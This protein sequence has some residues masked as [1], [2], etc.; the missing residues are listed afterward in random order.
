M[1]NNKDAQH[2]EHRPDVGMYVKVFGALMVLTLVTVAI[3]RVH[4][5]RPQAIALGLFVALIKASLV[6]A[7]F[8]H[9]WGENKLIHKT[10]WITVACAAILVL[11]LIDFMV[12]SRRITSPADVATQHPGEGHAESVTETLKLEA[13]AHPKG[14][15]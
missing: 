3:S 2:D 10:L 13:P 8:M 9:L 15:K 6:G 1:A 7:L 11:P 12:V 4:L 14:G 5:P